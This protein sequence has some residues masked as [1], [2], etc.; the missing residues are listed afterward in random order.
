MAQTT[1]A[2]D[3]GQA[4]DVK[5]GLTAEVAF[6]D[7][8]VVDALTQLGFF[9]IGEVFH[10]GV[11][12]DPSHVQDL[13]RAGSADSVDIS[14]TDFDSL[15]F[16]QVN[17][18]YTCHTFFFLSKNDFRTCTVSGAC[19]RRRE[20]LIH[21]GYSETGAFRPVAGALPGRGFFAETAYK[22]PISCGLLSEK[23]SVAAKNYFIKDMC[24]LSSIIF[25]FSKI[26][27][28][29]PTTDSCMKTGLTLALLVLGVLA[30]DHDFALALDDL[31]L[32]AHGLHGRSDFHFVIPPANT[33]C[34]SR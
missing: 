16:G 1:V 5:R 34:F 8:V 18:G 23:S 28:A 33:T 10:A 15:V 4:L 26:F 3:L 32:L 14:E 22:E 30:D 19:S 2:A 13:L 11:G 12:I 24:E 17:A 27:F 6:H 20:S 25:R 21:A 7:K 29:R 31:A 9:L